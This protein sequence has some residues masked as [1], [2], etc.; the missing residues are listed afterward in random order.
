MATYSTTLTASYITPL[1][2]V[3]REQGFNKKFVIPYTFVAQASATTATDV[4][5]VVL[6]ATP[7]NWTVDYARAVVTTAFT[8]TGTGTLTLQVGSTSSVAAFITAQST[9]AVAT[10]NPVSTIGV[11]TNCTATAAVNLVATFTNA[12]AGSPSDKTAG[13]VTIL[14]NLQ[15]NSDGTFQP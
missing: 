5:T 14:L 4:V 8:T 3:E 6:G 1:N 10:L 7:A 13:S 12:G 15:D 11:L 9:L 2:T